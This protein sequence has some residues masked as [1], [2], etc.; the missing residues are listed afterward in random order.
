[1]EKLMDIHAVAELLSISPYTVRL[2]IRQSKLI[3]V[4]IG[5][6][7][8]VEMAEVQKFLAE[9]KAAHKTPHIPSLT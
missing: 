5:R 9:A 6:R 1:M 4:R 2:Y 8:L 7:V 3:P